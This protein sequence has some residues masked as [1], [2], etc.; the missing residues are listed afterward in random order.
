MQL[1]LDRARCCAA[2]DGEG[3]LLVWQRHQI[4]HRGNALD[5]AVAVPSALMMVVSPILTV[6][7]VLAPSA[8]L[9]RG[10]ADHFQVG[11]N[12]VTKGDDVAG[13][14]RRQLGHQGRGDREVAERTNKPAVRSGEQVVLAMIWILVWSDLK[15]EGHQPP[16][17]R[18]GGLAAD[19]ADC[20]IQHHA[21]MVL[22][23]AAALL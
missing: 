12:L 4:V 7:V 11:L 23:V 9:M 8:P 1:E 2:A 10:G 3:D 13:R 20:G 21:A 17:A 6:S 16:R 14:H 22:N 5:T 19:G 18:V 15:Q